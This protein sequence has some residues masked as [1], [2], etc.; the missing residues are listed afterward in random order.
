MFDALRRWKSPNLW[1]QSRWPGP[2]RSWDSTF[3]PG[4]WRQQVGMA[5]GRGKT[6]EI[7][8]VPQFLMAIW[9]MYPCSD[10]P[11]WFFLVKSWGYPKSSEWWPWL[12]ILGFLN[13]WWLGGTP[14]SG[15][16]RISDVIW[17]FKW[18]PPN[19][20][21]PRGEYESRVDIS[22][23]SHGPIMDE[24]LIHMVIFHSYV[25]LPEG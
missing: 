22:Y 21:Q 24:L 11:K 2:R 25:E 18:Y 8:V 15:N 9:G 7:P 10:T 1:G 20:Q 17:Y 23:G 19:N 13:P 16:I 4:I 6:A 14:I 12:G 5:R 3:A